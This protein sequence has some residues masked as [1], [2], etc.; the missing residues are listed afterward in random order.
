MGVASLVLGIIACVI[1]VFG[2]QFSFVGSVCGLLAI[3]FG[4]IAKSNNVDAGKAKAGL[5]LGIISFSWGIAVT[6]C[7]VA[8]VGCV[9][10]A[11]LLSI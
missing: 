4:A 9:G 1:S 3:I 2:L 6:A 11:S 8:C 7:C 5:I 10:C